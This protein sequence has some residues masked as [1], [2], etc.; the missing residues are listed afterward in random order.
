MSID[1]TSTEFEA[2]GTIPQRCTC[3]GDDA[4]PTLEWSG[5]P[6][7]TLEQVVVVED[8][9]APGGTFTHLL[10]AGIPA[11]ATR[12]TADFPPGS[13]AGTNG[14]GEVGWRGPCPPDGDQPHRYL[15]RVLALSGRTGLNEGFSNQELHDAVQGLEAARGEVVGRFGKG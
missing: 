9:D 4:F 1:V 3:V 6:A 5:V 13:T 2:D 14:F 10:L 8:P 15:F 7:G 12:L 11:D